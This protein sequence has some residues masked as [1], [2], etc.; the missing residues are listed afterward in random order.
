MDDRLET[1]RMLRVLLSGVSC[2]VY[3][4]TAAG[5]TENCVL[6][7]IDISLDMKAAMSSITM[8][9]RLSDVVVHLAYMDYVTLRS[10]LRENV[11]RKLEKKSWD[12]LEVA[13]GRGGQSR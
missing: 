8:A 10:V 1:S 12:N 5:R 6:S 11:G 3:R 7:E 13:W 2:N 4:H 9:C